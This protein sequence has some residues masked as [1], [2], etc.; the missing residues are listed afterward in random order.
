[1]L[2]HDLTRGRLF[3]SSTQ[4]EEKE[5]GERQHGRKN[6]TEKTDGRVFTPLVI[7]IKIFPS[8]LHRWNLNLYYFFLLLLLL[9]FPLFIFF[10][11][12]FGLTGNE[13]VYGWLWG[14]YTT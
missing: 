5:R 4:E 14:R 9:V 3:F 1:L 2:V 10:F 6:R 7:I 13:V 12:T 11:S 8:F